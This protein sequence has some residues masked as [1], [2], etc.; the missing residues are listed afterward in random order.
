MSTTACER[1][2]HEAFGRLSGELNALAQERFDQHRR[3]CAACD[4]FVSELQT[5]MA[6]ARREPAPLS[7]EDRDRVYEALSRAV[8]NDPSPPRDER[9]RSRA[10][11]KV[12]VA[13]AL[14]ACVVLALFAGVAGRL[15]HR[16]ARS[17][18]APAMVEASPAPGLRLRAT[19]GTV[20]RLDGGA[21]DPVLVVDRGAVYLSVA[22]R[23]AG[24]ALQ[25]HARG[26]V[27]RVVGTV[28]FVRA[29]SAPGPVEVGVMR[30]VVMV[31]PAGGAPRRL[32]AGLQWTAPHRIAP[33]AGRDRAVVRRWL[34]APEH[35]AVASVQP[36]RVAPPAGAP[37]LSGAVA[38]GASRE[39]PLP[40][41]GPHG[42]APPE[43]AQAQDD[44]RG[45][46]PLSYDDAERALAAGDASA[47]AALLEGVVATRAGTLDA[48][49]ARLELAT[50]YAGPLG[51]TDRALAHLR[52]LLAV[53][54]TGPGREAARRLL[55]RLAPEDAVCTISGTPRD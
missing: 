33:L 37:A 54:P 16:P 10:P 5:A 7:V 18:R 40:G 23:P 26:V 12:T 4:R 50:L 34:A 39:S 32:E 48:D 15:G 45:P 43:V 44:P 31:E 20:W 49:T 46:Q 1:Y 3:G 24:H 35:P 29:P 38:P 25:V 51:R 42:H 13:L 8:A 55:C 47:A 6:E 21:Q 27:V 53:N 17:V 41:R 14:A 30:G 36:A 19:A 11:R 52:A 22:P 2:R 9:P 28:L